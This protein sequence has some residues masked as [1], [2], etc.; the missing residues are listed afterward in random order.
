M[1]ASGAKPTVYDRLGARPVVNCRGIYSE[2][3]GAV[4]GPTVWA[5]M[6]EANGLAAS[7][8]ELLES[9]GRRI[10]E[11]LGAEAA[12]VTPGAAAAIALG[13]A[14]CMTRGEGAAAERLPDTS[15]LPGAVLLQR[16]QSPTYKY[17]RMVWMTGA[18]VQAFGSDDGTSREELED[19]LDPARVA[20]VLVPAHVDDAPG[21]VPL[22]ELAPLASERGIP[23]LV[24]AAFLNYPPESMRRF[25]DEGADL[26]CFSA[27][28]FY[29]PNGGGFVVG[30]RDLVG[31]VEAVDFTGYET[32]RWLVFGRPFKLDRHTVVGTTLA[33]EEWFELDH[34]A[35]WSSYAELVAELA[36]AVAD[37]PGV[38]AA[39]RFFT[40]VETLEDEPV[41]CLVVR[42]EEAEARTSAAAVERAFADGNPRIA[43]H[44]WD[45]TLIVAVDAMLPEQCAYVCE[46]LRS[47]LT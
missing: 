27:K 41:N 26:V 13:T 7:M 10:A 46:R 18:Q 16:V 12:R 32:G 47:A 25:T 2:L 31:A 23:V 28:Y 19:S 15:G 44:R 36:E 5:A 6:T 14:A 35:R 45:D 1:S 4:I 24:D 40:M 34:A 8:S 33:L 30:R 39:P 43:V 21:A 17:A 11:L 37:L 20:A 3:G 9:T 29:G 42:V 38:S 22:R